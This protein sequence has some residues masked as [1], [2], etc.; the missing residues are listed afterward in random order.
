MKAEDI[1]KVNELCQK[2]A[3]DT[4]SIGAQ[5]MGLRSLSC[6][7]L[8]ELAAQV[9]EVNEKLTTILKPPMFYDTANIDPAAFS[10]LPQ[11]ITFTPSETRATL[12]D[13]FAMAAMQGLFSACQD[14]FWVDI[15]LGEKT[16][17]QA[18]MWAD[19]MM[20]ERNGKAT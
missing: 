7:L 17:T 8:T 19:K 10:D 5:E 20:E 18:Y 12:R 11:P 1:R 6:S 9:A 14:E 3:Q 13:Q 2:Q 15:Q 16:T 4:D